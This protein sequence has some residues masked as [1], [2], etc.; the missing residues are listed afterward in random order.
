MK[1]YRNLVAPGYFT[2][3][4]IQLVEGRDFTMQDD[5]PQTPRARTGRPCQRLTRSSDRAG[6]RR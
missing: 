6:W 5:D 1:I 2:L 4:K 3:M